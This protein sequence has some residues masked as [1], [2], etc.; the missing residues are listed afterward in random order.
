MLTIDV[1]NQIRTDARAMDMDT[2]RKYVQR[3]RRALVVDGE[4]ITYATIW[5]ALYGR[6]YVNAPAQP[7]TDPFPEEQ[8]WGKWYDRICQQVEQCS[9]SV[10][11]A[12]KVAKTSGRTKRS[13]LEL[14]NA[15]LRKEMDELRDYLRKM[16]VIHED[17]QQRIRDLEKCQPSS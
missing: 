3:V 15:Q 16:I 10:L 5:S 6:S 2:L 1:V 14:E 17:D 4:D 11:E 13:P 8:E 12:V 7:L 9:A